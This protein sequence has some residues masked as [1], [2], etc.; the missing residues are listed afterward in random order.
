[1]VEYY[2]SDNKLWSKIIILHISQTYKGL[3][4]KNNGCSNSKD[5]LSRHRSSVKTRKVSQT[6]GILLMVHDSMDTS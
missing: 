1:M 3:K 2:L 6:C 4:Y 5:K